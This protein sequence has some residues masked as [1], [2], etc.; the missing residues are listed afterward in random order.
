MVMIIFN[1]LTSDVKNVVESK[2]SLPPILTKTDSIVSSIN[3]LFFLQVKF[4][5]NFLNQSFIDRANNLYI[6]C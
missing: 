1:T 2:I 3:Y 4:F 6:A 5:V